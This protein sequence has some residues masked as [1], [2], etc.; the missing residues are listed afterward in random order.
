MGCV[1]LTRKLFNLPIRVSP[2]FFPFFFFF[3]YLFIINAEKWCGQSRTGR[4][5][6]DAPEM[7]EV[8][9][10]LLTIQGSIPEGTSEFHNLI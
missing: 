3:I 7:S 4:S 1:I 8:I 10:D 6:S 5:G 2:I 9:P